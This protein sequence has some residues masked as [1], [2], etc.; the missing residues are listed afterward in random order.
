MML[1]P[2]CAPYSKPE[3]DKRVES[4]GR[5]RD[6]ITREEIESSPHRL[7]DIFQAIRG[8]RPHFLAPP[9]GTRTRPQPTA[10][11]VDGI[12]QPNGLSTLQA[13]QSAGVER[14]EYLDP[15]RAENA[16]G[17]R[18][19]GGAVMVTTTGQHRV[20]ASARDTTETY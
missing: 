12:Y 15:G 1:A 17:G 6:V 7:V 9:T 14:V 4:Q 10:V 19:S 20:P 11:Y 5:Q 2:G 3:A 8:L 13:I 16:L 18:A